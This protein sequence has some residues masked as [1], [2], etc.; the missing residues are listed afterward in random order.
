VTPRSPLA[1]VS[2]AL[3]VVIACAIGGRAIAQDPAFTFAKPEPVKDVLWNASAQAG[4]SATAGDSAGVSVSGG[5]AVSRKAGA[6]RFAAE[7]AG[8]FARTRVQVALDSNGVP[9]IGPGEVQTIV[10]TTVAAWSAK[11]RYDRFFAAHSLYG[12]ASASGDEPSGKRLI[13]EFQLGYSRELLR[14]GPHTLR[15]EA[16]YDLSRQDYVAGAGPVTVHSARLFTAYQ[17]VQSPWAS[18]TLGA[19]LLTN[20][21]AETTPTGGVRPLG[22][23]RLTM[24]AELSMKVND[25]G[26]LAVQVRARY[27]SHPGPKPPPAGAAWEAGYVPAADAFN[28]QTQLAFVYAIL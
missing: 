4:L 22:D 20:L 11:L 26:R 12:S 10:A 28:A 19:E 21:T 25:R 2:R 6:D 9:G 8:A 1:S 24:R 3:A 13:G 18:A 16:G 7:L 27:E 14:G 15:L 23:D 17:L 5:G